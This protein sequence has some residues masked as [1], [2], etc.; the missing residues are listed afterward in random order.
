MHGQTIERSADFSGLSSAWKA[1]EISGR[2]RHVHQTKGRLNYHLLNRFCF[3]DRFW[4][5]GF[6][7]QD[8]EIGLLTIHDMNRLLNLCASARQHGL[9][10]GD[11]FAGSVEKGQFGPEVYPHEERRVERVAGWIL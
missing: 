11:C 9:S 7:L 5:V 4:F 6:C 3:L 2:D 10:R 8:L 1:D